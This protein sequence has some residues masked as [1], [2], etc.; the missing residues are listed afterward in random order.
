MII[1]NGRAYTGK[2]PNDPPNEEIVKKIPIVS[3]QVKK[4][5][6]NDGSR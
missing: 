5:E 6:I 4:G 3:S 1:A 2:N